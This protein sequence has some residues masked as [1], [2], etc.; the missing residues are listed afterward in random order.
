VKVTVVVPSAFLVCAA[1]MV[2]FALS[3]RIVTK[4]GWPV[5][6]SRSDSPGRFW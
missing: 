1:V 4:P 5:F 3:M 6:P 2:G